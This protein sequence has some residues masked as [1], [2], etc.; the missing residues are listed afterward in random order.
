[1]VVLDGKLVLGCG[2]NYPLNTYISMYARRDAIT[3]EVLEP[4]TFILTYPTV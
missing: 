3:N 1:M 2:P 4:Y